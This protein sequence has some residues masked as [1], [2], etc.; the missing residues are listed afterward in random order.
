MTNWKDTIHARLPTREQYPQLTID[1]PPWQFRHLPHEVE[2]EIVGMSVTEHLLSDETMN[3]RWWEPMRQNPNWRPATV[4]AS[5]IQLGFLNNQ[6]GGCAMFS[7]NLGRWMTMDP[8]AYEAGDAN[9]FRYVGNDPVNGLDPSGLEEKKSNYDTF[10]EAAKK[11]GCAESI[12]E[13][14]L[15][16]A[17][18]SPEIDAPYPGQVHNICEQWVD[19]FLSDLN[20]ALNEIGHKNGLKQACG[21][22]LKLAPEKVYFFV[23]ASV[24]RPSLTKDNGQN[25][26]AVKITLT[27]G[28]V[29]Y[30]DIG[31]IADSN[32]DS[33]NGKIHI[34][35]PSNIPDNWETVPRVRETLPPGPKAIHRGTNLPNVTNDWAKDLDRSLPGSALK[36]GPKN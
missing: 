16:V 20:K 27:D 23:P 10:H 26:T 12:I 25:H 3:R 28:S 36:G 1:I 11:N 24:F 31:T 17:K 13:L 33:L 34:G 7:P 6:N 4:V 32:I 5:R 30:V 8:I 9:L 14:I 29:F 15:K 21:D 19:K 2:R 35:L 18:E 22:C